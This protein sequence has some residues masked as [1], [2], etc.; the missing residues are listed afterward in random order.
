MGKGFIKNDKH[1]IKFVV[2]KIHNIP[3]LTNELNEHLLRDH[4]HGIFLMDLILKLLNLFLMKN[5]S[6]LNEFIGSINPIVMDFKL[7][8]GGG[9]MLFETVIVLFLKF[10]NSALDTK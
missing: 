8:G 7:D 9:D 6:L 2:R 10:F 1:R 3:G 5:M 4:V